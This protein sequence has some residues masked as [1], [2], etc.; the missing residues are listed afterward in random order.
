[1]RE[2]LPARALD[3]RHRQPRRKGF[4][5][6]LAMAAVVLFM[7]GCAA[8]PTDGPVGTSDPVSTRSN[9]NKVDYQQYNPVAGA[10]P[11]SIIRGFIDSGTGIGDD[12]Q[13]ARQYLTAPLA[14][15]WAADKRTLVYTNTVSVTPGKAKDSYLVK[16]DTV[17]SVDSTG[18]M[19]P[20]PAGSTDTIEMDLVQVDGEWRIAKTPDGVVLSQDTFNVL[21]KPV[22]LYFY[23][24][25][26]T[27]GV[28][29]VR[30]LAGTG[31]R[32]ATSIVRDMLAGPAPYLKGAVFS[33]FPA[34]M[35][36]ARDSVSVNNGLA[37]VGLTAQPLLES[38]VQQRQRMHAQLL[39][40]LRGAVNDV[41]EV[42]FL[43]DDRE[44]DMGGSGDAVP[45]MVID[46]PVPSAQVGISKNELAMYDGG[47]VARVAG[48]GSVAAL[49]PNEP[50]MSYNEK[51]FAFLSADGDHAFTVSAGH[52]PDNVASG[53]A[54]TAPSFAPN[55]WLWTAAGDGSGMVFAANA[56]PGAKA[57]APVVLTVPWLTGREVT[58][59]RISRD[60]TRAL[61]ISNAHGESQVSITGISVS[62]QVP[63]ALTEPINLAHEGAPTIGV[64]TGE[65]SVAAMAPSTTSEVAI[66]VLDFARPTS[67]LAPLKGATWLSAGAGLHDVHAQTP[68]QMYS[69]AG[70]S[71]QPAVK[72]LGQASYA[73]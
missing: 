38:S 47:T 69:Q 33:A 57:A 26:Y 58:T 51:N 56:D 12:F 21:F 28:P 14:Q 7:A 53:V 63:K 27:Y 11:E 50:A 59:F 34:G 45:A 36:L 37:K 16:F 62:G 6:L 18:V 44:V 17:S 73:G 40:S 71:W 25:T 20:A 31:S 9:S 4:P 23:D 70:N 49:G 19:T 55:G 39:V 35:S 48:L 13:T 29:D 32:T 10:S 68:S 61:V 22:T 46:N 66:Q 54:L 3:T 1:M 43:A 5:A 72:G 60:G 42:Q 67:T 2:T 52:P 64:W 41:T 24:S 30:W 65:T 15:S 8:I